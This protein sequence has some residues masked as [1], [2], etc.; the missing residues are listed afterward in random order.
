MFITDWKMQKYH[1]FMLTDPKGFLLFLQ[2][3]VKRDVPLFRAISFT[4]LKDAPA[5]SR[6]LLAALQKQLQQ[7]EDPEVLFATATA[8]TS[9]ITEGE[10]EHYRQDLLHNETEAVKQLIQLDK[11]DHVHFLALCYCLLDNQ[12]LSIQEAVLTLL[13]QRSERG[14][15]EAEK[16]ALA[17]LATPSLQST[18]A[19]VLE[20][21]GSSTPSTIQP[22]FALAEQEVPEALSALQK[23]V[24]TEEDRQKILQLAR[25]YM[26]HP[27]Y[28]LRE[29]A[30][31]AL[32]WFSHS[33]GEEEILLNAARMYYDELVF[34]ATANVLPALE[35]L[36]ARLLLERWSIMM[37]SVLLKKFDLDFYA[38]VSNT[39]PLKR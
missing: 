21:V 19:F 36:V 12:S 30:L 8:L 32:L 23:L 14:D 26:I 33:T 10:M 4:L 3:L 16:K 20:F 38:P 18:A 22:L 6:I 28:R 17:A 5:S 39:I 24:E 1:R 15:K 35:K 34:D 25:R 7:R 37:Q 11:R 9:T 29:E 31:Q 27:V 2:R 13:G